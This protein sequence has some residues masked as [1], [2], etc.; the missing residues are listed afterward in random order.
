VDPNTME[1]VE[2]CDY[3]SGPLALYVPFRVVYGSPDP[4]ENTFWVPKLKGVDGSAMRFMR[5]PFPEYCTLDTRFAP[6]PVSL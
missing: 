5:P 6:V 1:K 3:V 2:K 4:M